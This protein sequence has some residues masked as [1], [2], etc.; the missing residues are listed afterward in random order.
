MPLKAVANPPLPPLLTFANGVRLVSRDELRPSKLEGWEQVFSL[1]E[2]RDIR[3]WYLALACD[4]AGPDADMPTGTSPETRLANAHLGLQVA[5]PIG[6]F[7][8]VCIRE[9]DA[10]QHP[11][12]M[13]T[14]FERFHGTVWSRMRS[15]NG[16]TSRE[17]E[18]IVNGV[19]DILEKGDARA[20][21]PIRLFEH[22][23][24]STDRYIRILLWV[25]AMDGIL[26]AVKEETF[27]SRLCFLLGADS[28]VFPKEDDV[29][30]RRPTVVRDVAKDLFKLRSE[31]AHGAKIGRR[32]WEAREDLRT[33]F[34]LQAYG[35]VPP[36]YCNL[37]EESALSLLTR[38]LR[39]IILD[40]LVDEFSS[41]K[42]W[43]ARLNS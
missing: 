7:L 1:E 28:Q 33:L 26:M 31:L 14:R 2:L 12:L 34:D 35:A 43:K 9:Q 40:N 6:T 20:V 21:N 19:I 36:R 27:V 4:W 39:K 38:I 24:I 37:L 22:G 11:C 13:M 42:Q 41:V 8:S 15:F 23:L 5:A 32:F 29:Y 30:I 17:V 16:M 10:G 18:S 3:E 25:T